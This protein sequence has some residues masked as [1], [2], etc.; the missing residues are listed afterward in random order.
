[1]QCVEERDMGSV[2]QFAACAKRITELSSPFREALTERVSET[3]DLKYLIFS[4]A[5]GTAKFRTL[6]SVLCVTDRRWL[7]VLCE[8]DGSTA[9]AECSYGSTLLVEL[10]LILLYGQ[11]K[12]H[13]VQDS[14]AKSTALHFNTVMQDMYS[15]A[16]QYVLDAI[17][18]QEKVAISARR[19]G[20]AIFG[21]WPLKFRNFSII[22]LPKKSQLS[23]G[24]CWKEI[25]GG[26]GREL[27]P[28]AAVLVTNRHIIVIAEEKTSRW[29]QFR[30][31]A[32][33]GATITYFPVNRL[34]EFRI[35]AHP[36]FCI[37]ELYGYEGHG[38][39]RLDIIFPPD[40]QEA[41]S[42]VM[43][44]ANPRRVP[45]SPENVQA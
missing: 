3:E 36:R 23:D 24:V 19:G 34:A 21:G 6:A 1:M 20:S 26:F 2:E 9:V 41:V 30:H 40:K 29:F 44:K 35:E 42:R 10:T 38:G 27:A 14:E 39:E 7:I 32:K 12:F 25:R 22:Y 13:F 37:L 8:D 17:D 16:I 28:A 4:P 15:D 45:V 31:R 18:G 5:F 11:L 33:Y 43:G